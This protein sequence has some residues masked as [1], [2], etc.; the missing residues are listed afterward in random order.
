MRKRNLDSINM[1][2]VHCSASDN[3]RHDNI[4]TIDRWHLAKG[5]EGCGYHFFIRKDGTIEVGRNLKYVGA[6]TKG[7]NLRSIGICLHG[8]KEENFTDIQKDQLVFLINYINSSM[9]QKID[10]VPHRVLAKKECPV[11]DMMEIFERL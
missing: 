6:H 8:L 1:I 10:V 11:L 2:V 5:W 3:P 7:F 9:D 4:E